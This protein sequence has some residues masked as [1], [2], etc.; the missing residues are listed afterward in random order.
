MAKGLPIVWS[1]PFLDRSGYAE[2]ARNFILGLDD[3]GIEVQA[4]PF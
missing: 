1:A 4:D 3:L 2:E